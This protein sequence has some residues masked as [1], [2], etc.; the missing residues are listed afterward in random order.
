MWHVYRFFGDG[1]RLLYVGCSQDPSG[2]RLRAHKQATKWFGEIRSVEIS[3]GMSKAD[4]AEAE[5]VA[6]ELERPLYNRNCRRLTPEQRQKYGLVSE[7]SS[8]Y[9]ELLRHAAERR[10]AIERDAS[11]GLT[12]AAIGA[13]FGISRQRVHQIVKRTDVEAA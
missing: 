3:V 6:I 2:T 1:N 5:G 4:A 13:K 8:G 11:K 9:D 7:T 10:K 12:Y